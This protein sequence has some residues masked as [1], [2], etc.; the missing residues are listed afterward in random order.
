MAL[1]LH[2][3][4]RPETLRPE[5]MW[6]TWLTPRPLMDWPAMSLFGEE[7]EMK[8][9]EFTEGDRIV[10]RAELPGID[11]EHDVDITVADHLLTIRAERKREERVEDKDGYRSEF[12]YGSF[13]R[14]MPL[15]TGATEDDITATY[16]DGILEVRVPVTTTAETH[17]VEVTRS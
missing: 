2:R 5:S 8:V 6:P 15:P 1:L 17:K 13:V 10:V 11:P 9:E 3:T 16:R 4:S 14:T 12:T 7:P